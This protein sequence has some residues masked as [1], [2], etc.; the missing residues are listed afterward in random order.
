MTRQTSLSQMPIRKAVFASG[1]GEQ[2]VEICKL[3]EK[4][5]PKVLVFATAARDLPEVTDP[6]VES[7]RQCT[8]KIEIIKLW[9]EA[10]E[11]LVALRKKILRTDII[12]F[13]GGMT[14]RLADKISFYHLADTFRE[15]YRRG[16]VMTGTSAGCIILCHAGFNDFTD[17]RYDL[18]EGMGML[19]VFFCPHY[20]GKDWQ[21]F[22]KRLRDEIYPE[23]PSEAWALE[24]GAMV[25]FRNEK[26]EIKIFNPPAQPYRFLRK[27][28]KWEKL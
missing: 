11:D 26:P 2:I 6:I 19:P 27:D 17:G 16:T 20:Q 4:R 13:S 8:D 3:T 22:D 12:W 25:I 1:Y 5:T 14:E 9:D 24:D 15:A 10:P 18:I 23:T 21:R 28:E 7:F